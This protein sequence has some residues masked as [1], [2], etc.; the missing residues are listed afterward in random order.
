VVG[1]GVVGAKVVESCV[2]GDVVAVVGVEGAN[3]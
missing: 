2:E 1:D 3:L